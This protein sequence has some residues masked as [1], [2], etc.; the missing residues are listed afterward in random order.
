MSEF[1]DKGTSDK[2]DLRRAMLAARP[3]RSSAVADSAVRAHLRA[4][5]ESLVESLPPGQRIIAGHVPMRGEP[6]AP[7]LV[8][9]L[10]ELGSEL[11]LPVLRDDLDLDW[12]RYD[13]VLE[14]AGRGLREP[15]GRRLG[16]GEI[17]RAT[18][19][20]VPAVAVDRGGTRLGRGGGSYDR[21]LARVPA[22]VLVVALLYDGELIEAV[23]A[24]PH[25]RRVGAVITPGAGV[26]RLAQ[27]WTAPAFMPHHWHSKS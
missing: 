25:D 11:L 19:V 4:L 24:R 6:G 5:L 15:P 17:A 18:V 14:P 23:P 20:V 7:A 13:G 27:E 3:A 10:S 9:L 26:T 12:T 1:A 16:T 8:D 22:G 2:A 21:A